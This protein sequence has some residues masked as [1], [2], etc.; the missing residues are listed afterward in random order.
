MEPI[1][2][3]RDEAI[4]VYNRAMAAIYEDKALKDV[5]V[6]GDQVTKNFLLAQVVFRLTWDKAY[7]EGYDEGACDGRSYEAM[8]ESLNKW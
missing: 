7:S 2:Y 1:V 8:A 4:V 5:W 3:D 6:N